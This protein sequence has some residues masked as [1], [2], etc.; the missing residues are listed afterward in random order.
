MRR[1]SHDE[2]QAFLADG[3]RTAT[4][5]T[6]RSDGSP[7]VV[8]VWFIVVDGAILFTCAE[9]SVKARNL[10]RDPRAAASVDDETFPYAFATVSG[11]V[12]VQVRPAH[13]LAWTTRIARRYVGDARAD[14]YGRR[15]EQLDDWLVRLTPD[16]I[17]GGAEVAL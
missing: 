5:A 9:D 4:V 10:A 14:E 8:P 6:T 3:V 16:R 11:P 7:H 1:M 17:F 12:Q 2:A 13:F 15:N